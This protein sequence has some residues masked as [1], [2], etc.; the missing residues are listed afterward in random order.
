MV[1]RQSRGL[2]ST[3]LLRTPTVLPQLH[4]T[5][6]Q[7]KQQNRTTLTAQHAQVLQRKQRVERQVQ[8]LLDAYQAEAITLSELQ[9]RRQKLTTEL[10][11][12]D[13]DLLQLA[14]SHQQTLHWQQVLE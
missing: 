1:P 3:E 13:Q 4:H 2:T 6:A 10:Q 9:L 7:A 5:W 11:H 12:L 14:H 8:R